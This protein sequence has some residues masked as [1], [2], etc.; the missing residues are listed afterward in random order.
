MI[1]AW[2]PADKRAKLREG[3]YENI[4]KSF[5]EKMHLISI[6]S[7]DSSDQIDQAILNSLLKAKNKNKTFQFGKFFS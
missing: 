6:T 1:D 3:L 7:L 5:I 2:L 4:E